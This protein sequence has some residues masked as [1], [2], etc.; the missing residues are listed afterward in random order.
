MT[1]E[2]KM[3]SAQALCDC[4]RYLLTDAHKAELP[5]VSLHLR[6]AMS[7]AEAFIEENQTAKKGS[8]AKRRKSA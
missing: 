3:K 4:I 5:L 8:Q 6:I 1:Q 2:E 7:E